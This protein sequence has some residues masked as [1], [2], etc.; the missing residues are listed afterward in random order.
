MESAEVHQSSGQFTESLCAQEHLFLHRRLASTRAW[1]LR[2]SRPSPATAPEQRQARC[3]PACARAPAARPHLAAA[4]PGT[5]HT[6]PC[7]AHA[8]PGNRSRG[9]ARTFPRFPAALGNPGRCSDELSA[10]GGQ[11]T[12]ARSR[13]RVVPGTVVPGDGSGLVPA[14]RFR[15][16][17]A[18]LSAGPPADHRSGRSSPAMPPGRPGAG[19]CVPRLSTGT[20]AALDAG[21]RGGQGGST[22]PAR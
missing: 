22:I 10:L 9:L 20:P 18:C 12:E 2:A 17:P 5:G 11:R 15:G 19:G 13:A 7:P 1:P 21:R 3:A 8:V 16:T 14:F 6:I 4:E